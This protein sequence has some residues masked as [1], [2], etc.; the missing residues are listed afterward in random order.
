M[1]TPSV[2]FDKHTFFSLYLHNIVL[3]HVLNMYII[4]T[5]EVPGFT[6]SVFL[7]PCEF[8]SSTCG[9]YIGPVKVNQTMVLNPGFKSSKSGFQL[10]SADFKCRLVKTDQN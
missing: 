5:F 6:C 4:Y 3:L 2:K 1:H 8:L 10:Y 7:N 9:A